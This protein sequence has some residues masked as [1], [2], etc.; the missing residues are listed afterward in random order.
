M[1]T[2]ARR[3]DGCGALARAASEVRCRY[4]GAAR[5]TDEEL[6][7]AHFGRGVGF[8]EASP[9]VDGVTFESFAQGRALRVHLPPR[10]AVPAEMVP[11]LPC[12]WPFGRGDFVDLELSATL[13]FETDAPGAYA[14]FWLRRSDHGRIWVFLRPTGDVEAHL[15]RKVDGK[16]TTTSLGSAAST[17]ASRGRPNVLR[18]RLAGDVLAIFVN[19][20]PSGS[21]LCPREFHGCFELFAR[22]ADDAPSRVLFEDPCAKLC[23]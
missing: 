9:D 11:V 22:T 19:G 7:A 10:T 17:D 14:G 20:V 21:M 12:A 23:S 3:C 18:A 6:V 15:E 4:C 1:A 13:T 2:T 8:W 5:M 16:P